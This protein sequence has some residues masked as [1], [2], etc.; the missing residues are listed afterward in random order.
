MRRPLRS[1]EP[2]CSRARFRS[3][4]GT[5]MTDPAFPLA[6]TRTGTDPTAGHARFP[7]T[8]RALLAALD[9]PPP[10]GGTL[11]VQDVYMMGDGGQL[12]WTP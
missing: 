9:E 3:L 6:S 4:A 1:E 12:P 11:P 5:A 10:V 7:L 2:P 8:L